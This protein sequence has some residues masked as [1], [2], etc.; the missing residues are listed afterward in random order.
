ME[1]KLI[2]PVII[3]LTMFI[4]T[5]VALVIMQNK[6]QKKYKKTIEELDY[7][8]NKLIGVPILSELSKVRELVKTD[9]L[10]QKLSEWDEQFQDI[11]DNKIDMLTDLITEADFLI[12]RKDYKNAIKKIAYIEMTLESLKKKTDNLLE[13]VKVITNSEE[14]NR[15]IVTKLKII[16]RELESKFERT[17]KDYGPL[18]DN[19]KEE[20]SKIDKK[21]KVFET[22]MDKN[23]Y[24]S[25]EKVVIDLEE[26]INSLK[27]YLELTPALILIATIMIPNKIEETKT[28]Y[29]RMQRDGY[30][31]DYLNIEYNIKEINKKVS[32]I[33]EKLKLF[34]IE[35][36]EIELK[37]MLDY[38]NTIFSSFDKEK[39]SK[40]IFRENI[41]KL[42]K[43]LETVNKVVY[44]IYIQMDDIKNTYDLSD[45]EINKFNVI[46]KSLEK[47]NEDYKV[48][49]EHGKGRT[50]AYSKLVEELDGLSNRLT[51]LQDDLDYRLKSITSMKD[52]EYRAKEQLNMIEQL[53][54]QAK[55]K[56]KDYK[57][58]VIPN[59]Y[60]IELKEAG[61][62][63]REI[64]KELDKKPIVIKILNIRVD[65]ARD[66]VFKIYNKTN[67]IVK[68]VI[69]CEKLIVYGNR[70]RTNSLELDKSLEEATELFRKGKYKQSMDLSL[71]AISKIDDTVF[72]R[73]GLEE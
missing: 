73:F 49:F 34:K 53:L 56:L 16:H 65:T 2:L 28:Q 62:A 67:D 58:P 51:R 4:S 23:D 24:V 70:Y 33:I 11:K 60:F 15:S 63:I 37:T 71:K 38:F 26:N 36:S 29:F 17:E 30:P 57:I 55:A 44:D 72:S 7:E 5:I 14:R 61:E 48:L 32:D 35:N 64:I 54:L 47:I 8:K 68:S 45:S 39:E 46:N 52:D 22:Y 18:C 43:K 12:E 40:D 21:F 6:K 66:L 19:I 31:L 10:K 3:F 25:V 59:S 41:K 42:K 13:E 9:N 1:N 69:L 27:S 20:L 50:F